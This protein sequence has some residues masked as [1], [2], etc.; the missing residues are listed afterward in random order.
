MAIELNM[1]IGLK[2]RES[3]GSVVD[4]TK[5]H[6]QQVYPFLAQPAVNEEVNVANRTKLYNVDTVS[7]LMHLFRVPWICPTSKL[8]LN[9]STSCRQM[10]PVD[11]TSI[12][13]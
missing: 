7:K 1:R 4:V 5:E 8:S 10:D 6:R 3:S 13:V 12:K 9:L 2:T 11:T